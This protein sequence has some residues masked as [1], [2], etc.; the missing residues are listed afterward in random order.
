[1][2]SAEWTD[3]GLVLNIEIPPDL[4]E[5]QLNQWLSELVLEL[6]NGTQAAGLGRLRL[7]RPVEIYEVSDE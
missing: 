4:T 5:E 7:S 3:E 6:S 1:M 2:D